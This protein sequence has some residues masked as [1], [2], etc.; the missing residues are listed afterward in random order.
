MRIFIDARVLLNKKGGGVTEYGRLMI[1]HLL[2]AGS[3]HNFILF[4]NRFKNSVKKLLSSLAGGEEFLGKT[5]YQELNL[6]I[7]NRLFDLSNFFFSQPK[8]DKLIQADIFYNPHFNNLSLDDFSKYVLTVHDLSFFHFPDFFSW[9]QK[10]WHWRQRI[11]D[12]LKKAN[13]IIAVSDFTAQDIVEEFHLP[14]TK[15]KRIYAGVNPF[16]S[17]LQSDDPKL[18]E[19]QKEKEIHQP[20]ILSVSA[21]EPRKNIVGLIKT[22]NLLKTKPVFR[23]LVLLIV[24]PLGWLYKEIFKEAKRSPVSRDIRFWGRATEEEL[25]YLYNLAELFVYPS[26]FEG[27]GF[28]PLEAQACGAPVVASNRSSL[29]EI[30]GDSAL[31]VDPWR[32]DEIAVA[33]E[34]VLTDDQLRQDLSFKGLA[35]IKR[36]NWQ[37]TAQEVLNL[38]TGSLK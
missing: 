3:Q 7:P 16:F 23:D 11:K 26:F 5:F 33:I 21:L 29:P 1:S 2:M 31:L 38:L 32:L 25:K 14:S 36:F 6:N 30:I 34:A 13:Q 9:R 18:V 10:L 12:R 28:P 4:T 15:V 27:F 17:R 22:F 8:I 20:F 19:F 24:G 37:K 35:N